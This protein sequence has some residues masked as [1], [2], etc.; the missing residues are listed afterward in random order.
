MKNWQIH[1]YESLISDILETTDSDIDNELKNIDKCY[2]KI[3]LLKTDKSA[4]RTIYQLKDSWFATMQKRLLQ[5]F[6][7][8]IY[9]PSNVF[10]FRKGYSYFDYLNYHK[11]IG[12]NTYFLR[13]DIR[14]F[15][16]SIKSE[17]FKESIDYY[18]AEDC[19]DEEREKIVETILKI[20]TYK[21]HFV[22]GSI[23]API[24]SNL[25][26]RPLDIRI[27]KYCFEMGIKYSRYADDLLFSSSSSY[28]HSDRFIRT[29]INIL[30]DRNFSINHKKT[31][32]QKGKLVINGYVIDDNIHLSR[33]KIKKINGILFKIE[34]KKSKVLLTKWGAPDY[35]KLN[36]LAGYRSYLIHVMKYSSDPKK[37]SIATTISRIEDVIDRYF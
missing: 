15:F 25:V 30:K 7:S 33:N 27:D 11:T 22:Q 24:I 31:L 12:D 29:I 6:F 10:G 23:T 3:N 26:F 16:D 9:F 5:K 32:R 18:I 37:K 8:N 36:F 28:L 1:N 21:N 20:T 19:S 17:H 2:E 14:N 35:R 13:L 4:Y 34:K